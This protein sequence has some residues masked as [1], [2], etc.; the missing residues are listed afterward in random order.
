MDALHANM[1]GNFVGDHPPQRNASQCPKCGGI[2][3]KH[4]KLCVSCAP[5]RRVE[6]DAEARD[7]HHRF[8]AALEAGWEWAELLGMR[9]NIPT[10]EEIARRN[11][12]AAVKYWPRVVIRMWMERGAD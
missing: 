1:M 3:A 8:E 4:A 9:P 12:Q 2:K 10:P 5:R 6:R 7:R 11:P